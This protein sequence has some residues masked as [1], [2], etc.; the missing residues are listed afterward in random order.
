[1]ATKEPFPPSPAQTAFE[2]NVELARK[3]ITKAV[4]SMGFEQS[5][6]TVERGPDLV[7]LRLTIADPDFTDNFDRR[8]IEGIAD[9]DVSIRAEAFRR[10]QCIPPHTAPSGVNPRSL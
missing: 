1:M 6:F 10:I 5:A 4:C 2:S 9:G 8:L 3:W 7:S